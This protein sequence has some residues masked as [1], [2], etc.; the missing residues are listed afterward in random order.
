MIAF[1][2]LE[3]SVILC[4]GLD[5]LLHRWNNRKS[6]LNICYFRRSQFSSSFLSLPLFISCQFRTVPPTRFQNKPSDDPSGGHQSQRVSYL[7][8]MMFVPALY[9]RV[10]SH[11]LHICIRSKITP[12]FL[13]TATYSFTV[14]CFGYLRFTILMPWITIFIPWVTTE[15]YICYTLIVGAKKLI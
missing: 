3:E 5:W 8:H 12:A 11:L 4:I 1:S 2:T 15:K 13:A 14:S 6:Y 9:I 7:V 10:F